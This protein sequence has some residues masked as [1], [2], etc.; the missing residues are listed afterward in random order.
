MVK[1]AFS[2]T[3]VV[4]FNPNKIDLNAFLK[5]SSQ[6][7]SPESSPLKAT[8]SNC[9]IQS[10]SLHPLVRQGLVPKKLADVFVYSPPPETKRSMW[11]VVKHARIV[12]SKKVKQGIIAKELK[13]IETY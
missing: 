12:T 4:L 8:C 13:K 10:V 6:E 5:S 11:K 3:G 1:K 7:K 9:R 2:A